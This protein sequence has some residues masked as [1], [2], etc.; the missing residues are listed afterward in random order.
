VSRP[1]LA[2][3]PGGSAGDQEVTLLEI[4]I[5]K[6]F[7]GKTNVRK[8]AGDVTDLVE[9]I[10]EKGI[11]EP[12]LARPVGN[13]Y[14]LVVGSRRYA[15]AKIVGLKKIPAVVRTLTEEDAIVISLVENIQRKELD[16]EEEYDGLM[17]LKTLNPGDYGTVDQLA[18]AV[19]KS[20]KYIQDHMDAV[21]TVRG[22]RKDGNSD[23]TVKVAPSL[24]E[25]KEGAIPIKHATF[26]H[27]AEESP[28][29]QK[30]SPEKRVQKMT[31]LAE[32]IAQLPQPE[33]ERIVDHFVMA[34][35]KPME[36]I[37]K[38]VTLL[39]AVKLEVLL[40]PRVADSLR[41]AA[42]DRATTMEA[43]ASL[44]IHSWLRQQKYY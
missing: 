36:E 28:A 25:R 37:K 34:P 6:L 10:R 7:V 15:A 2:P 39:R 29:V 20:H 8:T 40:D 42:E 21:E 3:G 31:E 5:T 43:I 18:K 44:A 19:G 32:T 4:D 12:V 13:H 30:L 14:E 26:L 22:L 11:L 27:E 33:A 23:M 35:R 9:S 17:S 1:S 16:P 24:K 41:A 38:E